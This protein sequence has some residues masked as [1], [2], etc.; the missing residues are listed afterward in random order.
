MTADLVCLLQKQLELY[1]C[2]QIQDMVKLLY[3]NEF[4]PGHMLYSEADSLLR[5]LA[6]CLN[7]GGCPQKDV[8]EDIGNGLCRL[9]LIALKDTGI[10]LTTVNRF[11]VYTANSTAGNIDNFE[12]KMAVFIRCC[13]DKFLPFSD[14]EAAAW[15]GAY[16]QQGYPAVS[17]SEVF[18]KTCSPA[19]RVVKAVFRDFFPLFCRL[20]RMLRD[21]DQV[22]V[23][24][25]GP[26]GAGKSSLAD[27]LQTIYDCNV[28]HMDDFFLPAAMKTQERL[29]EPGGNVHYERLYK[30]V[31]AELSQNRPFHYRPFN[32]GSQSLGTEIAVFPKPLNIIEGAYSLH[33]ALADAYDLKVFLEI[34]PEEQSKRILRRN[35]PEM[36]KRFISQWI[37]LENRYFQALKIKDQCDLVF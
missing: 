26:C 13:R 27:L 3:Q 34:G 2:L 15:I 37:P 32:C 30:E 35:G 7:L 12:G 29:Q 22:T 17:H 21:Q 23:A 25:D 6:E 14:S 5:L 1:P 10:S 28:L 4:G 36:L 16:R 18:R 20:D 11:F 19:Y 9:H 24:I 8:F 31:L 33:P